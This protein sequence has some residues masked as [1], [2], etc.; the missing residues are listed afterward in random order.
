MGFGSQILAETPGAP[1]GTV[2]STGVVPATPGDTIP[3]TLAGSVPT[4]TGTGWAAQLTPIYNVTALGTVSTGTIT[5]NWAQSNLFTLTL[6][7][8]TGPTFAFSN[9]TVGQS[10]QMI[11]TVGGTSST[12]VAWPSGFTSPG[13]WI[14]TLTG[15]GGA[16]SSA[17]A[18]GI[19][20]GLVIAVEITCIAAGTYIGEY[21]TN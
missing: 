10:I 12:I 1:M 7:N 6:P 20:A 18:V 3:Y 5:L 9:V 17:P 21:L 14:G 11:I 8:S 15:T 13:A 16:S 4:A 19:T 2:Q